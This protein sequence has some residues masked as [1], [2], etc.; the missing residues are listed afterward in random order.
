MSTTTSPLNSQTLA[1]ILSPQGSAAATGDSAATAAMNTA[2]KN[3]AAT[4]LNTTQFLQLMTTQ[5]K[6]QNPTQPLDP[7]QF[8]SQLA[9]L[10]EVSSVE[11]M[12]SSIASLVSS[13]SASQLLT[14]STLVGRAVLAPGSSVNLGATGAVGGAVSVP[15][16]TSQLQLTVLD[17]AGQT[18]RQIALTPATGTQQFA[19]DG[20][21]DGGSRA[22][23]GTY[24]FQVVAGAGGKST[25]LA[26]E[27]AT[28]VQSV[29]V[30]S[31]T[32]NLMLNTADLG[33]IPFSS[34]TQVN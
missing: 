7:S 13:L 20:N 5:L 17:G 30:D 11:G 14:G 27:V 22:P 34:V 25:Q 6:N 33:S 31:S 18:V 8:V 15:A 28:Q 2:A 10:S 32:N 3:A 29:S 4:T 9:Q 26:T 1:S 12:Q 21:T 16:G 24:T 19:W 23:S